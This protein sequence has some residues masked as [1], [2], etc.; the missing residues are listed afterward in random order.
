MFL[1]LLQPQGS[2]LQE[3]KEAA[4][5]APPALQTPGIPATPGAGRTIEPTVGGGEAEG[6]EAAEGVGA[7]E[8]GADTP[9]TTGR[10]TAWKCPPPT[11]TTVN[12]VRKG[13]L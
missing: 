9:G 6:G 12:K 5:P 13:A 7:E 4:A 1:F 10:A 8:G 2:L 11:T 3:R